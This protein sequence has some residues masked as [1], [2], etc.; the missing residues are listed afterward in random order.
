[1]GKVGVVRVQKVENIG[2][3][4][5]ECVLFRESFGQVQLEVKGDANRER[6]TCDVKLQPYVD[7]CARKV[8]E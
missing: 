3:K 1:M 5:R 4:V 2:E 7:E 8:L 6:V